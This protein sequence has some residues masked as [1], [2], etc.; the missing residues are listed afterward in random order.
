[1]R[2]PDQTPVIGRLKRRADFVRAAKG[3]RIHGRAF[4]LQASPHAEDG[5]ARIGFT[6]TRKVG[7]AVI[8]N[9]VRRRLK[10]AVRLS[11]DLPAEA[12]RDYV[13]VGRLDAIRAPFQQLKDD[14]S[15]AIRDIR[16]GAGKAPHGS[17]RPRP[18]RTRLTP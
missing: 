18:K 5:P 6:L 14:L 13:L 7:S 8:R 2:D 10:E 3:R 16:D 1:M 12:G 4:T 17:G 11:P 9:R 15:R